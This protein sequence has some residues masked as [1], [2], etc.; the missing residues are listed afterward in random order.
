ML[1]FGGFSANKISRYFNDLWLYDIKSEKWSQP[2][3]AQTA[4]DANGLPSLK[5]PWPGVPEARGAHASTFVGNKLIIFG[6]YGGTGFS[7]RDFAD[8]HSLDMDTLEWEEIDMHGESPEARSGHQL[9]SVEDKQL[10]VMGGWNSSRQFDDVHI[11]DLATRTWS[12]PPHASGPDYWGTPRWNYSAVAVFAVPY[13]KI[14]VFGG[15]SGDLVEGKSPTGEYCNDVMVLECGSNQWV[16]PSVVGQIP[17]PRSDSP[18]AYNAA[19][20]TMLLFGGW[21]HSWHGDLVVCEVAEVVGPPYSVSDIAPKI[22]PV[23]GGTLAELNGMGFK[24]AN[25]DVTVRF[26]CAKGFVNGSHGTVV[27]DKSIQ[28]ETPNYEEYGAVEVECRVAIGAKPLTNST[29]HMIYFSVTSASQCLAY[30]PGLVRGC[31]AGVPTMIIIVAKDRNGSDRSCGMDEFSIRIQPPPRPEETANLEPPVIHM[32]GITPEFLILPDETDPS[33]TKVQV[34]LSDKNDGTYVAYFT[35]PVAG[36]YT[37]TIDFMGTFEGEA[38]PIRGSPFVMSAVDPSTYVELHP[39][40]FQI[41]EGETAPSHD[42]LEA[43]N[44]IDGPLLTND[45]AAKIKDIRDFS[46]KKKRGLAKNNPNKDVGPLIE[47]KEHLRSI[48]QRSDQLALT[49]D[50]T[51]A[52]LLGLKA[53][54]NQVDRLLDQLAKASTEW[55]EVLTEAPQT[56]LRIVPQTQRFA[57]ETSD[58]IDAYEVKIKQL[59]ASFRES[60]VFKPGFDHEDAIKKL[61]QYEK[62]FADEMELL[63]QN[64]HLCDVFDFPEKIN[65]AREQLAEM[66]RM[67]GR[68]RDVWDVSEDISCFVTDAKALLWRELVIED[69]EDGSKAQNKKLSA[70]HK[71]VKWCEA[72]KYTG[73]VLKDFINTIPLITMLRSNAMRP[74][75]WLLLKN[76][77]GKDFV[78]PYEDEDMQ[79]GG[80]LALNLHE[81]NESVE[82]ISD[83][84][85]KEEKIETNLEVL[86]QRWL[87]ISFTAEFYKGTEVPMLKVGEDDWES[88]ENDQLM[89][90]GMMASRYIAQFEKDVKSWQQSLVNISDVYTTI[91]EIQRTWSYLEPLFIHSDEVPLW[92]C[93]AHSFFSSHFLE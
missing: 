29:V 8:L 91:N 7:R 79:L 11:F 28:V 65:P 40:E 31:L 13:W 76:A 30:G 42:Q 69:L 70:L 20:G 39:K 51:R 61:N 22:G 92:P 26:A 25:G 9:L 34:E 89:V 37:V 43:I 24:S 82:E 58:L 64:A 36:E 72:F 86:K 46:V 21:R 93:L 14:F 67:V 35:P 83:Q 6:G 33:E 23:T 87:S 2:L 16:R 18:M 68:M 62:E 19:K 73:K 60:A 77:T 63:E 47:V 52:A 5:R 32:E 71:T 56:A 10:Y 53:N 55:S 17:A 84:A 85:D 38:G 44:S 81:Y 78:P 50:A 1:I 12:Q 75:H 66:Q 54:G 4:L 90:Q 74:R 48:E 27:N 41:N 59:D 80:L 88:L 15:N 49:I 45:I 57:A 3:P